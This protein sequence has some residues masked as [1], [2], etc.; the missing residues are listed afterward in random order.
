MKIKILEKEITSHWK[1][2]LQPK[3]WDDNKLSSPVREALLLIAKE[4]YNTL[5]ITAPLEDLRFTGSVANFNY[6]PQS[7]LD[8]HLVIDFSKV[9]E[10]SQLVK[11]YL[12]AKRVL[13][14]RKHVILVKGH[15]VEVY[16]ENVGEE[17]ISTGIY[18]ILNDEWI[19]EPSQ[20]NGDHDPTA[21]DKK[22]EMIKKEIESAIHSEDNLDHLQKI[23]DKIKKM[24][25]CGLE[26]GGIFSPENLAFKKLRNEGDIKRLTA[27]ITKEYDRQHSLPEVT[28]TT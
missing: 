24:R 21:G 22:A 3:I 16:V 19:V 17:H 26:E 8:L 5:D 28:I 14:N 13:W 27:A 4:F 10:S 6:T 12:D 15:E 9:G 20:T 11:N 23:K 18:S 1:D 25:S 2:E 7:D